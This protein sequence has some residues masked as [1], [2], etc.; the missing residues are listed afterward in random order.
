MSHSTSSQSVAK[1]ERAWLQM[2][3]AIGP[4]TYQKKDIGRSGDIGEMGW[5]VSMDATQLVEVAP[6]FRSA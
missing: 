2:L 5:V 3:G 1:D 6:E 4:L